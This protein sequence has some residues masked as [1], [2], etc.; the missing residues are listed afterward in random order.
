MQ[1]P[2]AEGRAD[3]EEEELIE[4]RQGLTWSSSNFTHERRMRRWR[5]EGND[6]ALAILRAGS[7]ASA[8]NKSAGGRQTGVRF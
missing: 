4:E 5:T 8:E 3:A 7:D 2:M 1:R 6:L